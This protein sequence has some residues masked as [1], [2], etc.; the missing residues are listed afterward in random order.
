MKDNFLYLAL[1][2]NSWAALVHQTKLN[3]MRPRGD[4][5]NPGG[6]DSRPETPL[7]KHGTQA[8]VLKGTEN[9]MEAFI[10]LSVGLQTLPEL[11]ENGQNV[12][13]VSPGAPCSCARPHCYLH[14][15]MR[16]ASRVHNLSF[17]SI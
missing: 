17:D 13:P 16:F 2:A 10:M 7:H 12:F 1:V 9:R 8:C 4:N 3:R 11:P 15:F 6:F 14:P 5:N